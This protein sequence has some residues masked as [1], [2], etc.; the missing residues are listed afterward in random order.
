MLLRDVAS[1]EICAVLAKASLST[2]VWSYENGR[3][4]TEEKDNLYFSMAW[5]RK[6]HSKTLTSTTTS[7]RVFWL[8]FQ[9]YGVS[10]WSLAKLLS[11]NVSEIHSAQ[12][13]RPEPLFDSELLGLQ[14]SWTHMDM[15]GVC[16]GEGKGMGSLFQP[17]CS[18]P[19]SVLPERCMSSWHI[20]SAGVCPVILNHC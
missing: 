9:H 8:F 12:S 15:F 3:F 4:H 5:G 1:L 13:L 2:I 14:Y 10:T 6:F 16:H 7:S 18:S 20:C 19:S 17:S 11:E